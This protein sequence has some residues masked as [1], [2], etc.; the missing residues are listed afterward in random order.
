MKKTKW[1]L[2]A[3]IAA[4]VIIPA[5]WMLVVQLEGE[6]PTVL[7]NMPETIGKS[8]TFTFTLSDKRSGLR[9][10]HAVLLKDGK[11]WNLLEENFEKVGIL[12]GGK[13]RET[14]I[15]VPIDLKKLG[16]SDGDA[17]FELTVWDY[18]W[19]N[20]WHG[21]KTHMEN[22]L[23]IDSKPPEIEILTKAHNVNQGGSGL[24]IY[25]L[26]EPCPKNGIVVGENFFPG[27]SGYFKDDSIH[28]AFFA[29]DYSQ[30]P[31]TKITIEASDQAGN[32]TESG[33]Y[34]HIRKKNFVKDSIKLSDQFLSLKIP[35][36]NMQAPENSEN[37]LLDNFLTVNRN[38]RKENE[39]FLATIGIMTEPKMYWEGTFLRLP[40]SATRAAFA[41]HREYVY[42]G[43]VVDRQI[44]LG[45]DLASLEK[46]PI[47]ASNAG[48]V[49]FTGDIGIY[50]KTV[51]I[52]HGFG[53]ISMYSH[54]SGISVEVG[55]IVAKGETIGR[56][57]ITGLAGGDHLHFGM[58]I[59]NTMIN[60][61]EWWDGNW[62]MHNVTD[63]LNDVKAFDL[64]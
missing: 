20:W 48:K 11:Q 33:F 63:K 53:L 40:N 54:L 57:G 37:P 23:L 14:S 12:G 7:E 26:S 4:L 47:P 1:W 46:S 39:Q 56:T 58:M 21:N 49:L 9:K 61:I 31:G 34:H 2:I 17:I 50:G 43:E 19:R 25:R 29:L 5:G 13:I 52:D 38:M 35:E 16:I 10:I 30:G 44:H 32:N 6:K 22:K 64:P 45:I 59:H 62:I 24:I 8:Q 36:F 42:N 60:P 51:V 27:Y 15:D 3:I 55:Q 18:S 28:L 41:D